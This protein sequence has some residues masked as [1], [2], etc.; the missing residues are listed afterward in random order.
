[1]IYQK[2][3]NKKFD[4]QKFTFHFLVSGIIQERHK[5]VQTKLATNNSLFG[6]SMLEIPEPTELTGYATKLYTEE[7]FYRLFVKKVE[8]SGGRIEESGSEE[9]EE[10]E[11]QEFEITN[12]NINAHL[13][14]ISLNRRIPINNDKNPLL[15]PGAFDELDFHV[16]L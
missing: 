7:D 4:E 11:N 9:S 5:I 14:C 13:Y 1:M 6:P 2:E 15:P 8:K 12:K 16:A 10:E 3:A